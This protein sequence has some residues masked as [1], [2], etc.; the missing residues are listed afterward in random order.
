MTALGGKALVAGHELGKLAVLVD[1]DGNGRISIFEFC[2]AFV[3][4]ERE[5]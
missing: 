3:V 4:E 5:R 1:K 2:A